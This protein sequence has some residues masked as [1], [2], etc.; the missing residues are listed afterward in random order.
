MEPETRAIL[1]K[2]ET[3]LGTLESKRPN[4]GGKTWEG[5]QGVNIYL[6]SIFRFALVEGNAYVVFF[7]R[8]N[9]S[10]FLLRWGSTGFPVFPMKAESQ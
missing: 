2:K 8:G 1:L 4:F 5:E 3:R 7:L 9:F 6:I 10:E